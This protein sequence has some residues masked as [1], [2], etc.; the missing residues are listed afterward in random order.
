MDDT[1]ERISNLRRLLAQVVATKRSVTSHS[2]RLGTVS[3]TP[4]LRKQIVSMLS[5]LK[6][7]LEEGSE[8]AARASTAVMDEFHGSETVR[9]RHIT[10]VQQ[11][12]RQLMA[13]ANDYPALVRGIAAKQQHSAP[14]SPTRRDWSDRG[15]IPLLGMAGTAHEESAIEDNQQ[16][17]QQLGQ[18]QEQGAQDASPLEVQ[19]LSQ[20]IRERDR[21]I[22]ELVGS[23]LEIRQVAADIAC[24]ID[25]QATA[26]NQVADNM[27]SASHYVD[28]GTEQVAQAHARQRKFAIGCIGWVLIALGVVVGLYLGVLV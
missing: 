24:L 12:E 17:Q 14:R 28:M 13:I 27:E 19:Q 26:V 5:R 21:D 4:A 3:D 8:A 20:D 25:H 16:Q 6:H 23:V 9:A 18:Q 2:K 11:M 10:N 1:S 22:Q 7:E 15:A